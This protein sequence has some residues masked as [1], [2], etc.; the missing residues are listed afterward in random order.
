VTTQGPARYFAIPA[1]RLRAFAA[2]DTEFRVHLD[3]AMNHSMRSKLVTA[4]E[5]LRDTG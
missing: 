2:A 5:R 4:N 1:S 3:Y